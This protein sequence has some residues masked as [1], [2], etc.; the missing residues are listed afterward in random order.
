MKRW[1]S[2]NIYLYTDD[3]TITFLLI[4]AQEVLLLSPAQ[5]TIEI[6]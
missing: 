3:S 6:N 4:V 5:R 1:P 2:Q